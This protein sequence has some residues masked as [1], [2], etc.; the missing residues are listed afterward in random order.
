MRVSRRGKIR[1]TAAV[2][3][4]TAAARTIL[5]APAAYFAAGLKYF[6]SGGGWPGRVGDK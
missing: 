6:R 4:R 1:V 3:L 5:R 2:S